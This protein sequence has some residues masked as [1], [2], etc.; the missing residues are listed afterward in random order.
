[1]SDDTTTVDVARSDGVDDTAHDGGHGHRHLGIALALISMAQL[2]VV[3]DATIVNIALPSLKVDLGF[4]NADLPWVVNAYTLAF[5]GL[6]LLG[7]R[8][9]DILGR[10][11]VFMFGVVLFGVASFL[12]GI[13]QSESLLLLS[14]VLQGVGAAAAS[15]NALALITT[16]FPAGPQRNRAMAVYAA[17]SGAGAAV[18]LILGGALTEA[19][20]RWTFFINTPIGIAVAVAALF[21]LGESARQKGKFDLAG[22]ITGTVGLTSLVYGLTHAAN[23]NKP[24]EAGASLW[25][26]I[27][28]S[29]GWESSWTWGFIGGGL[30]LVALFLLIEAR[31]RHALLPFRILANR[32]R[33]VSFLVMLVVLA[34]MFAMFYFLGIYIQTVLGYS[35]LKTG[36][37]FLP[38]SFGIVVAAQIDV[39]DRHPAVDHRA[40]DRHGP[41][42]RTAHPDRGQRGREGGLRC[43]LGGAEHD[44]A[45]RRRGR[46][47]HADDGLDERDQLEV[48][49]AAAEARRGRRAGRD[50]RPAEAADPA[51]DRHRHHARVHPGV[52][53][54]GRDDPGRGGGDAVRPG[55]QAR[56]RRRRLQRPRA[57]RLITAP[58]RTTHG[59][60]GTSRPGRPLSVDNELGCGTYRV[61]F[62][63][64]TAG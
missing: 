12:G 62:V 51:A 46:P 22:A 3:L 1:M 31:S 48:R 6:L 33:S 36:F 24:I 56:G 21:F 41:G 13:A 43:R 64:W 47:G 57:R 61:T 10:R 38:F 32:T 39:R 20:W 15:P 49:V 37:A 19:S 63:V 26:R 50:T 28:S 30:A 54:G 2:M 9:G 59:P 34:A 58:P 4:S 45:D 11:R 8:M 7:G 60:A 23:P 52:P 53:G 40:G 35:P 14:R 42:L 27:T 55:D 5:G 29:G 18:G 17:M 16:T 25:E 44:A